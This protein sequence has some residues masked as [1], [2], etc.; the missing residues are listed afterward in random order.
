MVFKRLI[1]KIKTQTGV[2]ILLILVI[3]VIFGSIN[4]SYYSSVNLVNMVRM[5]MVN[6][7]MAV[8]VLLIMILGGVDISFMAISSLSMYATVKVCID[9]NFNAPIIVLFAMGG[10]IG[11]IFGMFN[12]CFVAKMKLPPF[13]VSLGTLNIIK[14]GTILFLGTKYIVE[15]PDSM[16]NLSKTFILSATAKD[17]S[18][19]GLS[20]IVLLLIAILIVIALLLRYTTLGRNIYAIGGDMIAAERAGIN[21]FR[22]ILVTYAI[23]GLIW[24]IG[25]MVHSTL[26]RMAVPGDMIGN[27]LFVIAAVV[28]GGSEPGKGRGTILGTLMGVLLITI[29]SNNLTVLKIPGYWQQA[30]LGLI[31]IL[32]TCLKLRR[33]SE[34]VQE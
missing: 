11:V 31:I 29:I 25:G 12:A 32:G 19:T 4:P 17:G 27:E 6:C 1:K 9:L 15:I 3:S 20:I 18:E 7:I 14:G 13:I 22:N 2:L 16:I 30:V 28:L 23:A 33:R 26:F 5:G 8:G 10:L 21:I 34:G 24:G